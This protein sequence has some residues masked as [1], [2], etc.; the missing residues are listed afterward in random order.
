VKLAT[1]R[2]KNA[3]SKDLQRSSV[4]PYSATVERQLLHAFSQ[5]W[6]ALLRDPRLA[7]APEI[8]SPRIVPARPESGLLTVTLTAPHEICVSRTFTTTLSAEFRRSSEV[9]RD[10]CLSGASPSHAKRLEALVVASLLEVAAMFAILHEVFHVLGG[11]V[12]EYVASTPQALESGLGFEEVAHSS[13]I[14]L[15]ARRP[16]A[17]T[18]AMLTAYYREVEADNNALQWIMQEVPLPPSMSM[19][20]EVVSTTKSP[21][22]C[23]IFDLPDGHCPA[24]RTSTRMHNSPT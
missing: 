21:T 13:G 15:K 12:A 4:G 7:R 3:A 9:L 1:A 18:T 14:P 23:Q 16:D 19:L 17:N 8:T 20:V 5:A 24:A 6:P 10:A 2:K 22:S 11:H